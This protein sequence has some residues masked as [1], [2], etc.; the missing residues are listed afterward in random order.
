MKTRSAT[1]SLARV[2]AAAADA[3]LEGTLGAQPAEIL[4]L[5][6]EALAADEDVL[7]PRISA[8]FPA[9]AK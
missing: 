1:K 5:I 3:Q 8:A 9:H 4:N 6:A 2:E 7:Q